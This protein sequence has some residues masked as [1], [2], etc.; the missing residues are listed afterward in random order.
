MACVTTNLVTEGCRRHGTEGVATVALGRGLT[1][2]ILMGM[3]LKNQQR[4]ACKFIGNGPLGKVIVEA[5]SHGRVRGYVSEPVVDIPYSQPADDVDAMLAD[6]LSL[7]L[8]ETSDE[9]SIDI[10][11]RALGTEGY[12][13]VVKDLL[14]QELSEGI[15][16]LKT[17]DIN[18]DLVF[19]MD[20]SEQTASI[21]DTDVLLDEDG[22]VRVAGG[23]LFQALP[24]HEDS[25]DLADL[26]ASLENFPPI[27]DLLQAGK[28]PEE[29]LSEL[30]V[31]IEYTVLEHCDLS[32]R[33]NCSEE[34]YARAL[35]MLDQSDLDELIKEGQAVIDCH[36]CREEYIYGRDVLESLKAE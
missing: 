14:N 10:V 31:D 18:G 29:L 13:T 6:A 8:P 2:C 15:V 11:T 16:P 24:G 23:L 33:C 17:G 32:F 25:H 22:N 27:I 21:I 20:Q 4:I 7:E 34:R 36:F 19:Y 3:L 12:L 1:S 5:D 26:Q 35:K 9:D 30:L 28:L